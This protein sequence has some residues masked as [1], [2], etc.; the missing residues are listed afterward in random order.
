MRTELEQWPAAPSGSVVGHSG[1]G[2]GGCGDGV[3][4]LLIAWRMGVAHTR[5]RGL[6]RVPIP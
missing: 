5:V 1:T 2:P 3:S 4:K 6:A